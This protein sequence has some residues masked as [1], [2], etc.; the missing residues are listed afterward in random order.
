MSARR[1]QIPANS[2]SAAYV[3]FRLLRKGTV[4]RE[5]SYPETLAQVFRL[6]DRTIHIWKVKGKRG[7]LYI[8]KYWIA[9]K[10][11]PSEICPDLYSLSASVTRAR[12][13]LFPK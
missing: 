8:T 3:K 2:P 4:I 10:Y 11:E 6:K 12:N 9:G 13:R 5:G 7:D 1:N